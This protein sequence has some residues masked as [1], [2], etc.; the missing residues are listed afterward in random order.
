MITQATPSF[1]RQLVER[2]SCRLQ[3]EKRE[4]VQFL[5]ELADFDARKLALELGYPST[6]SCLVRELGLSE[7]SACRRITAARL[8][9][10]FPQVAPYL[11]SSRITLVGLIILKDV[12]DET[13]VDELLER[14]AGLRESELRQLVLATAPAAT[15]AADRVATSQ[16]DEAIELIMLRVGHA[17]REEL[18]AVSALLSHAVPSGKPEDVLLHVL[19]AQ[20]KVLER[21]RHGS[22]K[23]ASAPPAACDT[24]KR[25]IPAAVRRE[26]F[27][28]EGGS[29]AFVGEEG[30]RCGSTV[31]LEYQHIVP[32]ACGGPSSA[33][34]LTLFCQPHNQLQAKKDFGEDHV[35]NKC[36]AAAL[37]NLGYSRR[38]AE[39]AVQVASQ[40]R[41][42]S[43]LATLVRESL[44]VA[45]KT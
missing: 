26:V 13:N 18:A 30:R 39:H 41:P 3:N 10:R 36:A 8:L 40:Q 19:R 31:R 9:A 27:E 14:A 45:E 16:E 37:I 21:K 43:D 34:N 44:R 12:L 17:F 29:C 20:R 1:A 15:V 5:I 6:L 33:E 25:H 42:H 23:R 32:F 24:S 7:S 38:Q 4:L 35:T 22:P 11:L 28:R 2:L